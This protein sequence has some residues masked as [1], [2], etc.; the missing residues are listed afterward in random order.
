MDPAQ[1]PAGDGRLRLTIQN[2]LVGRT[3]FGVRVRVDGEPV[4]VER[5]ENVIALA[6]GRHRVEAFTV[7]VAEPGFLFE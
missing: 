2:P 1:P 3:P 4:R 6:A 7:F 5:G